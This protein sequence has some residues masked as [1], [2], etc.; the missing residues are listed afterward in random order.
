MARNPSLAGGSEARLPE[1]LGAGGGGIWEWREKIRE[2]VEGKM[3]MTCGA[4]SCW[5]IWSKRFRG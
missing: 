5:L 1:D 4:C 2:G 3:S